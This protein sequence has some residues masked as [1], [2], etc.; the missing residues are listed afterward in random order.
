MAKLLGLPGQR[1]FGAIC[2]DAT[3]YRLDGRAQSWAA[4]IAAADP[5]EWN[6]AEK[7]AGGECRAGGRSG[8]RCYLMR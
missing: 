3:F 7:A 2:R 1:R 5:A 8:I 6:P 4:W